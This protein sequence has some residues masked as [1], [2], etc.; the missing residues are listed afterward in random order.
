MPYHFNR[1][2]ITLGAEVRYLYENI[3]C[4]DPEMVKR[5]AEM[6]ETEL[7]QLYTYAEQHQ[8]DLIKYYHPFAE[9]E[10]HLLLIHEYLDCG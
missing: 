3:S 10:K 5:A 7:Q 6:S 9:I 4:K 1:W 2:I 8:I